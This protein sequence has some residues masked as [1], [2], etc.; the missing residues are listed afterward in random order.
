M[1]IKLALKEYPAAD[2]HEY[3]INITKIR[4]IREEYGCTLIYFDTSLNDLL[5]IYR[6]EDQTYA[7]CDLLP[8]DIFNLIEK[9]DLPLWKLLNE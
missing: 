7:Y 9:S 5:E 4:A 6:R 3:Y 1:F 2:P 8:K